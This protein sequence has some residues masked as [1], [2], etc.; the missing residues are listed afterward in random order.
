MK[1]ALTIALFCGLCGQA[2][3]G[4]TL[5]GLLGESAEAKIQ[6]RIPANAPLLAAGELDPDVSLAQNNPA[7]DL[8][9]LQTL[10]TAELSPELA[11]ALQ[12]LLA[13]S[14]DAIYVPQERANISMQADS[15]IA[16]YFD[17]LHPVLRY[18]LDSEGQLLQ[19]LA[20]ADFGEAVEVDGYQVYRLQLESEQAT[21]VDVAVN[22]FEAVWTLGLTQRAD[23]RL[24]EILLPKP[25]PLSESDRLALLH[26]DHDFVG[27]ALEADFRLLAN[28]LWQGNQSRLVQDMIS[29][30]LAKLEDFQEEEFLQCEQDFKALVA[31]I[32]RLISGY[33]QLDQEGAT[34]HALLEFAD[35]DLLSQIDLLQG[36]LPNYQDGIASVGWGISAAQIAPVLNAISKRFTNQPYSCPALEEARN[37]FDPKAVLQMASAT[38]FVQGIEG[39]YANLKAVTPLKSGQYSLHGS[40]SLVGNNLG[41]ILAPLGLFTGMD[42][43]ILSTGSPTGKIAIPEN[44]FIANEQA[45]LTLKDDR[46]LLTLG[47]VNTDKLAST[48]L[49]PAIASFYFNHQQSAELIDMLALTLPLDDANT[50][51]D[52]VQLS[53]QLSRMGQTTSAKVSINQQGMVTEG[54]TTGMSAQRTVISDYS[55]EYRVQEMGPDCAWEAA[56]NETLNSDG[57]GV[58]Q[59][60]DFQQRYTWQQAGLQLKFEGIQACEGE[61]CSDDVSADE[62]TIVNRTET[63]FDCLYTGGTPF[64]LRYQKQ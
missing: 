41:N 58:Y 11:N 63:G 61:D 26:K 1:A 43:P 53:E 5:F 35:G 31:G 44:E 3:A 39:I 19:T 64:I 36:Q 55:G 10:L 54:V 34:S 25:S 37:E 38:A 29:L 62:C 50:C 16:F 57:S 13:K 9:D 33:T 30:D 2:A 52:F 24:K 21:S 27:V 18:E 4:F 48:P 17:G 14:L 40:V 49:E 45:T 6:Q 22:D 7:Q 56:G 42:V 32:P 20:E 23:A 51:Y 15:F 8:S 12:V 46:L 28:Q 59:N 60:E 47:D